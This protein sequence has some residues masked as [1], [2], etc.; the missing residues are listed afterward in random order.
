VLSDRDTTRASV[1]SA[2]GRSHY[3]DRAAEQ[4]LLN[5]HSRGDSVVSGESVLFDDG[6]EAVVVSSPVR[7]PVPRAG[8]GVGGEMPIREGVGGGA[9][10]LDANNPT[11]NGN[12]AAGTASRSEGGKDEGEDG[13][14]DAVSGK[15]DANKAGDEGLPKPVESPPSSAGLPDAATAEAAQ[16]QEVWDRR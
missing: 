3:S 1:S 15:Q 2:G 5:R 9:A 4:G 13:D 10:G 14:R 11:I 16:V 6:G 7:K 8:G 12:G